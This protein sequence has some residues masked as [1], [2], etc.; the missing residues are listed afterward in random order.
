MNKIKEEY[1]RVAHP[2]EYELMMRGLS[3]REFEK[4]YIGEWDL[5]EDKMNMPDGRLQELIDMYECHSSCCDVRTA[6]FR[7][8]NDLLVSLKELQSLRKIDIPGTLKFAE[9]AAA[10]CEEMKHGIEAVLEEINAT[11]KEIPNAEI[12]HAFEMAVIIFEKHLSKYL[13]KE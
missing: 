5:P 1:L 2:T 4:E 3:Q 11:R 6:K 9:E 10:A 8:F 13:D 7:E 12:L